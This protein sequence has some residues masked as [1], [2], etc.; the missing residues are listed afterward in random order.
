MN[1][2]AIAQAWPGSFIAQAKALAGNV[3]GSR[4][5]RLRLAVNELV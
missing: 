5:L 1:K 3:R 2:S 4:R